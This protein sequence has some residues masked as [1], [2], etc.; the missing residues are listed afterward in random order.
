MPLKRRDF[1]S[2]F[3]L[4]LHSAMSAKGLSQ[5]D[6]AR[7]LGLSPTA[8]WN[9][10]KG[11]T[12]PREETLASLASELGLTADYLKNGN[13]AAK[14]VNQSQ[15]VVSGETVSEILSETKRKIARATGL[16]LDQVKLSL[17]LSPE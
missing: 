9:W 7:A 3:S 4:R 2:S 8:V 17:E 1:S 15:E 14:A 11:N 10:L 16:G 5:I 12:F 13:G 6:V